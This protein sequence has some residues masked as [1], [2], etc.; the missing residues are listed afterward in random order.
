MI[1]DEILGFGSSSSEVQEYINAKK[2][3]WLTKDSKVLF[4]LKY[5][6][7]P[8]YGFLLLQIKEKPF[9]KTTPS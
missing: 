6:N 4:C 3:E 8:L 5:I 2:T 1:V 7:D 9:S